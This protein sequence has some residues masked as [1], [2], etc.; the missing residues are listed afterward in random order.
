MSPRQ[1][2]ISQNSRQS[3]ALSR[4]T[5]ADAAIDFIERNSLEKLSMR[6]LATDIGCGTMSLYSYVRNR[7]DL[8]RA[9]VSELISRSRLPEIAARSFGSW[10]VLARELCAAYR[11][12][13]FT[14]PRTHELLGL[15]PY[16]D[17]PVASYL[18]NLLGAFER[19]GL[20]PQ[21]AAEVFAA[22]D[23]Y[24]TGY[25]AVSVRSVIG[26]AQPVTEQERALQRLR[27]PEKF[28]RG[29]DVFIRGFEVELGEIEGGS[30]PV[31]SINVS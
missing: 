24:L 10:Q 26:E 16:E 25:F 7:E 31:D 6:N 4:A 22:L 3:V 27:A 17:E 5:I 23:A 1:D 15:A 14:F 18:T 19:T 28:E 2:P 30:V 12:L 8:G 29:L 20:A 13:A 11:D 21:Q 9:I